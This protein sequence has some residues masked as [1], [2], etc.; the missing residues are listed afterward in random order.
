LLGDQL[1]AAGIV[2]LAGVVPRVRIDALLRLLRG[3]LAATET[4]SGVNTQNALDV[5][6][7]GD[8][9]DDAESAAAFDER[10]WMRTEMTKGI[11]GALR[12]TC[13]GLVADGYAAK[14]IVAQL[15]DAL[16]ETVD[17]DEL[18]KAES[19]AILAET[20]YALIQGA[21]DYLQLLN[22]TSGVHELLTRKPAAAAAVA[23]AV[24]SQPINSQ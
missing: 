1:D 7:E 2:E 15:A 21:D 10:E 22:A 24:Q 20:D 16:L 13:Q 12:V 6:A 8:D 3:D 17:V 9:A 19:F 11:S 5:P 18:S 23:A 14:R 4:A